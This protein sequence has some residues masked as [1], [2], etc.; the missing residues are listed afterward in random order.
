MMHLG[1]VEDD[2]IRCVYHGWKFDCTGQCVDQPAEEPGYNRKAKIPTYPTREH[3]GLIFAYFGE[4]DPPSFPPYPESGGEGV[5]DPWPV[6][7]VP[8]NYLQCFENSMDEV[9]VAFTHAPGGSHAKLSHDLP[10]ITAEEKDWGILRF[11]RRASGLVRH[12]L[13][14]APNIVRVIVP[15][16]AGMDGVGGWPEITFSFTPVDDENCLWVLT[17]K[18]RV[19]GKDAEIFL[20]KRAELDRKR[21][22]APRSCR[23]SRICGAARCIFRTCATRIS[24]SSRTSPCKPARVASRIAR[25]SFSGVPMPPSSSGVAFWRAS[26]G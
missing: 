17:S 26:C 8:C 10:I 13:H 7:Q 20:E 24:P 22:E 9:H 3:M 19:T 4:G 2:D 16:L 18:A 23:W 1:W 6:Y 15:P 5:I 25:M 11:G 21:A 12:T 14:Y